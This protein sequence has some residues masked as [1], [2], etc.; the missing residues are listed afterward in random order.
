MT[1]R[2]E[3][4]RSWRYARGLAAPVLLWCLLLGVL[5][6][7]VWSRLRGDEPYDEAV[8]R[9]W[10]EE[11]RV[12]REP[13]PGLIHEYCTE[14]D[15]EDQLVNADKIREQLKALGDVTK[16]YQGY[17]PLFPTI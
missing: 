13:L 2:S 6:E 1:D 4:S 7:I 14:P 15:P 9:E 17:L 12:Y 8:L 11:S 3:S 16:T 10:V 5:V